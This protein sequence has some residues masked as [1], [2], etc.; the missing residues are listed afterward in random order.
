[1]G[2]GTPKGEGVNSRRLQGPLAVRAA[3]GESAQD[4][5]RFSQ[6]LKRHTYVERIRTDV[7]SGQQ[8]GVT[9]TPTFFVNGHRMDAADDAHALAVV[10][11][12][13]LKS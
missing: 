6:A 7:A 3:T 13:V 9:G 12:R 11:R 4:K 5:S 2:G 8:H 10:I 1:M